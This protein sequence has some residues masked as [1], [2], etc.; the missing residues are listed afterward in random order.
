MNSVLGWKLL[1][2]EWSVPLRK[3]DLAKDPN[4]P[5]KKYR[6]VF[7]EGR[8]VSWDVGKTFNA[9]RNC[10]HQCRAVGTREPGVS[11]TASARVSSGDSFNMLAAGMSMGGNWS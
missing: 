4:N 7:A 11:D 1:R 8:G 10:G 2:E 5:I 9:Q 3:D 6:V